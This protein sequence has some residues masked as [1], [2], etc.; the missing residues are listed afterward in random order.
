MF[1][2]ILLVSALVLWSSENLAAKEQ[3][4]GLVDQ[5]Q[6]SNKFT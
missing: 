3:S 4:L 5:M 1:L 2:R 6:L